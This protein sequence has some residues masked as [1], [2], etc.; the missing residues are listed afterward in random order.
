MSAAPSPAPSGRRGFSRNWTAAPWSLD[1]IG[2]LRPRAQ[3]MLL[4][5]LEDGEGLAVGATRSVRVDV[6]VIAATHRDLEA[7]VELG[8]F[9][10]DFYYRLWGAV[11]AVPALRARR[12]DISLLV[13][14][15]RV[16]WNREDQLGIDG[17][18]GETLALLEADPWPGNVR[19]LERVVH[20]AM[21][22]RRRGLVQAEDVKLPALRRTAPAAPAP[23]AGTAG[24]A[25]TEPLNP[26]QVEALRLA[27][28]GGGVRRETLMQ[29]CGISRETARRTLTSLVELGLL[30][31]LGSG[32]G[33]WYVLRTPDGTG[34]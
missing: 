17:F 2:E 15:F 24:L 3:S 14:H 5:F 6:R 19:E 20:R 13:E 26:Y 29:R 8:E 27:S 30:R 32:R 21:T 9:R 18:A 23:P 1:E 4:R 31:R 34:G 33:A 16:R 22:V 10:E 25:T 28:A 7:A 12:E 11:L